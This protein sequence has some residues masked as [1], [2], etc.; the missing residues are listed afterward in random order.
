MKKRKNRSCRRKQARYAPVQKSGG[1]STIRERLEKMICKMNELGEPSVPTQDIV[2][3]M[4][5][6][7]SKEARICTLTDDDNES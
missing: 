2:V 6:A 1:F 3:G 4:A 7:I 5:D